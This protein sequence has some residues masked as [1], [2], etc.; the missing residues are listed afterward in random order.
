M[1]FVDLHLYFCLQNSVW[2]I[3]KEAC[4]LLVNKGKNY[5]DFWPYNFKS[6]LPYFNT[7]EE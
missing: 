5:K 3:D 6:K 1:Y 2:K 7:V 4:V